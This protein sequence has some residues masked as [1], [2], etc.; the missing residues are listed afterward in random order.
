MIDPRASL[1]IARPSNDLDRAEAFYV[2]GLGLHVLYRA[3]GRPGQHDL[4]MVG[5]PEAQWHLELVHDAAAPTVP[6]PT[7]EDLLVLYLGGPVPDAQIARLEAVGG[8]RVPAH[9]PYWD[10]FGVTIVDPDGYRLVLC[11]RAWSNAS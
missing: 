5:W 8:Q 2:K 1:R 7:V 11:Q 10:R 9:N 3:S 6:A 4:L